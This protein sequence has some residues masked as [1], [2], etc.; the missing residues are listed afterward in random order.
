MKKLSLIIPCYNEELNLHATHKRITSV[1]N[2]L[3][4][5]DYEI[6]FVDNA[7]TDNSERVYQQLADTDEQVKIL[8]M[9]RNFGNSQPSI[10]AGLHHA[11]GDAVVI[12]QGDLQ[13]PPELIAEF[14]QLWEHDYDVVYGIT[15]KR[16][17]SLLRR[18]GYAAFY[19][20]FKTLSYLNIPLD[21]GDFSLIDR[22]VVDIIKALPE[23]DLYLRGLR[24]WAGFKQIGIEYVRDDR[25]AGKTSNSFL[26][27]FWWAKKAIVNFSDKPLEY[28]SRLAIG[29]VFATFTAAFLYLFL[30]FAY[31]APRGFATLLMVM[32]IFG[33]LQLMALAVI[34]EYLIKIFH[35]VKGRPPYIVKSVIKGKRKKAI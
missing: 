14:T 9:S 6:L 7:S 32:F 29:A 15:K 2:R 16:K 20:V 4:Q 25:A 12:L 19:R 17:G 1:M 21:A 23:K 18:I 27:N 13:D 11:I 28:I 34:A 3:P 31:G 5:Y 35:E 24:S 8:M 26:A 30:Y 10:L 33:S 22:K